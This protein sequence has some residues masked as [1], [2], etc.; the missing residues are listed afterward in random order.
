MTRT[1][2]PFPLQRMLDGLSSKKDAAQSEY[3]FKPRTTAR[4]LTLLIVAA[5]FIGLLWLTQSLIR[6]GMDDGSNS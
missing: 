4:T 5:S 6:R 1:R 3:L 2:S